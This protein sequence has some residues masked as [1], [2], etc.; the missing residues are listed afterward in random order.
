MPAARLLRTGRC[1]P[2][3][4]HHHL[5]AEDEELPSACAQDSAPRSGMSVDHICIGCG[6]S[7]LLCYTVLNQC[8]EVRFDLNEHAVVLRAEIRDTMPTMREHEANT[9]TDSMPTVPRP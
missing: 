1:E 4:F 6:D 5:T 9:F 7:R 8:F 2:G 3:S